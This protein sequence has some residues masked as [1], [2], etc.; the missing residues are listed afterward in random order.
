VRIENQISEPFSVTLVGRLEKTK[1][2][3]VALRGVS[4]LHEQFPDIAIHIIG[5]GAER[6][7]LQVLARD[8]GLAGNVTFYGRLD[9]VEVLRR[10]RVSTCV[11]VPSIALEGFS[12]VA[13]E[14]ALLERPVVASDVG[15]LSETVV[16]GVTGTIV[17]PCDARQIAGAVHRYFTKPE[18]GARHGHAGRARALKEFS[19]TRSVSQIEEVYAEVFG[20]DS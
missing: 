10:I 15:G 9:R 16:N 13:L 14:S 12:L 4:D 20:R 1:G 5:V 8:L 11:V 7:S 2:F 3:D 19:L 17:D 18:T 6:H